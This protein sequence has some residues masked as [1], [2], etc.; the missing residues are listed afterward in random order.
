MFGKMTPTS[1][2]VGVAF[3]KKNNGPFFSSGLNEQLLRNTVHGQ[4]GKPVP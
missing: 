3:G 1:C 4:T 2:S